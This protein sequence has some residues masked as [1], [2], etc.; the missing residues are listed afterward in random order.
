MCTPERKNGPDGGIIW[1][2]V[3][4]RHKS[5][6]ENCNSMEANQ[7]V[8][9]A[10]QYSQKYP[11][12]SIGIVTPF[13]D[14]VKLINSILDKHLP[15]NMRDT[16]LVDTAHSFQGDERDVIIYSLVVTN[17]SLDRK[18]KYIDIKE[19]NL[20]NVAVTRARQKL[21]IVGN[22][23]Y[24]KRH[25]QSKLPLGHLELYVSVLESAA[26]KKAAE[27]KAAAENAMK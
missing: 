20:V 10:I 14:Q 27:K 2:D 18:I 6:H 5:D 3:N 25:S 8:T 19:S 24:I 15:V 1:I 21:V 23:T 26:A 17:N 13:K 4:G 9:L 12:C 16:I 7:C 22:R 11:G